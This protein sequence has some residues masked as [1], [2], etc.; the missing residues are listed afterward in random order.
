MIISRVEQTKT[1]DSKVYTSIFHFNN[2]LLIESGVAIEALSQLAESVDHLPNINLRGLM[3][4]PAK[5][6]DINA[7]RT[8]FRQTAQYYRTLVNEGF[9]LD[10]LSMG[11]SGDF[12]A[13]I[14]EGSTIIRIGTAIFGPRP[15]K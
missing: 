5:T 6:T 11:M 13:A 7:Q 1:Q 14:A 3:V 10:T 9:R 12:E 4:I 15:E 8:I 2:P